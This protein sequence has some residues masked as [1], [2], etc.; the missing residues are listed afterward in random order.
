MPQS[1]AFWD[2]SISDLL[3]P[4]LEMTVDIL[5]VRGEKC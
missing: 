5:R 4:N 3:E 2:F 1:C